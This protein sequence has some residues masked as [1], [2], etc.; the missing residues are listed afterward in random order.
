M[1]K[2]TANIT[3]R[4]SN[5]PNLTQHP[6]RSPRA[7][8]ALCAL[9]I[10]T[11][12][13][14]SSGAQ[15]VTIPD[16]GLNAA[17]RQALQKPNGPLTEPD[18]L[19]LTFLSAGGRSISNVTGLEFARN[20]S[21]LDL[22]HNS[23]TNF[24]IAGALT[25]LTI[26]DLFENQLT[27]FVLSN[28]LPKLN[29]LDLAFNSLAQCSLPAGLT[30]LDTLFLEGNVLKS[31]TLPAGLNKLRQLD[32]TANGLNTFALPANVTNLVNF[33][34]FANQLTNLTLPPNLS[35]LGNLDLDFNHLR[36]LDLPAG[37][38]HLSSFTARDNQLTNLTF[39]AD[40]TNL[41]FVDLEDNQLAKLALPEGLTQLNFLRV[42]HNKLTSFALPPGMT[43][44]TELFL[45]NNQLTN[46][47][48][49]SDLI[50]L[51][52][53]DLRINNLTSLTL[54]PDMTNLVTLGLD[55]NPLT[56]LVLSESLAATNLAVTVAALKSRDVQVFTYP[57]FVQL[58]PVRQ[59]PIGAFRFSI[60]GPP[61]DY[62]VLSSTN[63]ATWSVLGSSSL[64]LGTII[65]T[66]TTSQFSPQKFYRALRQNPPD[67]MVFIPPNTFT[68][69]SPTNEL[70]RQLN[71]GPQTVVTLTHGFWIGKFEVTQA[72]YLSVMHTNPSYFLGDL[73]RPVE[74]VT[75]S[76]AANYC[77]KLT[78]R[79]LAA[80]HIPPGSRYRLPTEA[81]WEC[82][83]RAGTTTRFSYGD[84]PDYTNLTNYAWYILNSGF[85]GLLTLHPVG[86][87]LPNPWGLYDMEGNVWEWTQ[88]WLGDLPGGSVIDPTGPPSSLMGKVVRGGSY[89]FDVTDCRSARRYFSVGDDTD[90]GFRVVLVIGTQ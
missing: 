9:G 15:E 8:F 70:H 88:D 65:V 24:P 77:A 31:F 86:Q 6:P 1:S 19:G 14:F 81:E 56:T 16:P 43:N 76:D 34:C 84:D 61:G 87:K 49:S 59:Q 10:L 85:P 30:N 22:D 51:V 42:P 11:C 60:V 73:N 72:E 82:A 37:L 79:E 29:I 78:T 4:P 75:W 74:S 13:V 57:L 83:A 40:M 39:R 46:I 26:L 33:L 54:P 68:M 38:T 47:S 48:L 18:L 58:A 41:T 90:I 28:S 17:I 67:N 32:L 63:L 62:T 5:A 7:L 21:I 64:P 25:N 52:Q 89:D 36:S 80:G 66:D 27:G 53:L 3:I 20:L 2:K 44:L 35:G 69:G 23:I 12:F 50:H 71:E 45:Q 55:N